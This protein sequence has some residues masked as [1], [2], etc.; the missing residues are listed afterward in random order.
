MINPRQMTPLRV[1]VAVVV[2]VTF[3]PTESHGRD[4]A[5]AVQVQHCYQHLEASHMATL[6]SVSP[7]HIS[8][9]SQFTDS[10]L[11][12]ASVYSRTESL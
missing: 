4:F 5:T 1:I 11:T 7:F 9:V 10:Q 6:S 2:V 12:Q 8:T 3:T